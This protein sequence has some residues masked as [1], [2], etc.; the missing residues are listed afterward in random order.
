[1]NTFYRQGLINKIDKAIKDAKL[2]SPKLE[3]GYLIGK[4]KEILIDQLIK[5]M[6][7]SKYSTGSGKITDAKD[8][9]SSEVDVVI[10]SKELIPPVLFSENFGVYPSESVLSCIEVK[11]KLDND[12]LN[13]VFNK[14]KIIKEKIKYEAGEYDE[15]DNP[16]NHLL[17]DF[18]RE[19][20]AFSSTQ[21]VFDQYKKIDPNWNI[22]PIINNLCIVDVGCWS[23]CAKKWSFTSTNTDH[24]EVV[25]YLSNL[26]NTLSKVAE[27]RKTPR[28][29]QYLTDS[30]TSKQL[31]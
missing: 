3:H 17:F 19:L 28:I 26:I 23:F 9:V 5:P 11:S 20:F 10:Y 16:V 12:E 24:E 8:N 2:I 21:N 1:M 30:K 25:S 13:D 14:Y 15:N 31:A 22:E 18:T 4:F 6:L 29:G 7:A 27:S